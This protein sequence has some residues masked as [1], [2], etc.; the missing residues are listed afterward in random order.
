MRLFLLTNDPHSN[1]IATFLRLFPRVEGVT[2]KTY[3]DFKQVRAKDQLSV[4]PAKTAPVLYHDKCNLV[5][6]SVNGMYQALIEH[7]DEPLF[8]LSDKG[9]FLFILGVGFL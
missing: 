1:A 8:K 2:T 9:W 4:N 3:T 7:I 5:L 6:K